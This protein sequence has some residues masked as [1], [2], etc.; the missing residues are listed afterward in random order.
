MPELFIPLL[1]AVVQ[2]AAVALRHVFAAA[3]AV[4]RL[5]AAAARTTVQQL[6]QLPDA[7]RLLLQLPDVRR[8]NRKNSSG[9]VT[10]EERNHQCFGSESGLDPDSNGSVDPDWI[11][12]I[13]C[14]KSSLEVLRR[15][16]KPQRPFL[17]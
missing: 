7:V 13:L 12:E 1:L 14:S 17:K 8:L 9:W 11:S 15:P 5:A 10:W 4:R 3:L 6:Q 2:P 16:F